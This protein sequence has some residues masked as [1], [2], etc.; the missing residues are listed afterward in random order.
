MPRRHQHDADQRMQQLAA[1]VM[2]L[3]HTVAILVLGRQRHRRPDRLLQPLPAALMQL[4]E[5]GVAR[6]EDFLAVRHWVMAHSRNYWTKPRKK[7][8]GKQPI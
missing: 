3:W 1:A 6:F 8:P 7:S 2:V 5:I 4:S